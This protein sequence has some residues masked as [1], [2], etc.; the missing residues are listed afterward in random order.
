[1]KEFREHMVHPST[2]MALIGKQLDIYLH[3]TSANNYPDIIHMRV[4][5]TRVNEENNIV[6][7]PI[8]YFY[9]Y[10]NVAAFRP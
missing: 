4:R 9:C 7:L 8:E 2:R 1:M 5:I 3:H 10:L 6:A